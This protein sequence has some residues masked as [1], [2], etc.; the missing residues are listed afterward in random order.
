MEENNQWVDDRLAKLN[1]EGDWQP[2][3][4]TALSRFEDRRSERRWP[5]AIPLAIVGLIC[6]LLFPA[7][8]AAAQRMIVTPCLEA[9]QSLAM[10]PPDMNYSLNRMFWTIHGWMGLTA[11]DFTATDATG[12]QFQLSENAGKIVLLNFWATWCAPCK[13]EIPWFTDFQREYGNDGLVV[14]GVSM[15][16]DGWKAVR[17]VIE[18]KKINYRVAIGDEALSKKWGL[19]SLPQTMLI[20]R[21][22]RVLIKH[23]GIS[24]KDQYE[25][26]I[27]RALW[28][29]LSD[30]ERDRLRAKGL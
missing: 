25:R 1:P 30:A 10:S 3:V 15:D 13:K 28:S 27:V 24:S 19:E 21:D 7:P 18:S 12:A 11:P 5:R 17:P 22:G 14:I 6:V 8:R 4:T 16:E 2:H 23:V 20:S 9:C 26:E 29:R